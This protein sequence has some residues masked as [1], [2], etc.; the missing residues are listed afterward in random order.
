MTVPCPHSRRTE[1]VRGLC[2]NTTLLVRMWLRYEA[3]SIYKGRSLTQCNE[4]FLP[5]RT[6]YR[7]RCIS[8]KSKKQNSLLLPLP[9]FHAV[10]LRATVVIRALLGSVGLHS[11]S[12]AQATCLWTLHRGL[13]P[14]IRSGYPVRTRY[15]RS[16]IVVTDARRSDAAHRELPGRQSRPPSV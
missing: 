4:K 8:L 11:T 2:S 14:S 9:R 13:P 1:S 5:R 3:G 6:P 16:V 12:I 15:S 7:Y 10:L